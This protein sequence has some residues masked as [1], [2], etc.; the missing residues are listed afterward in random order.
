MLRFRAQIPSHEFRDMWAALRLPVLLAEAAEERMAQL[1][2]DEARCLLLLKEVR[3]RRVSCCSALLQ[4]AC[5]CTCKIQWCM[6]H[7]AVRSCWFLLA[8]L[9]SQGS[10]AWSAQPLTQCLLPC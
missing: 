10:A 7:P 6:G 1:P 5:S 8:C 2:E 9:G 4:N 3:S